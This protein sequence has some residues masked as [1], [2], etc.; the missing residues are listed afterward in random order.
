MEPF[1]SLKYKK[2]KA[3]MNRSLSSRQ[4]KMQGNKSVFNAIE[5]VGAVQGDAVKFDVIMD[6]FL[7]DVGSYDK[8]MLAAIL[9]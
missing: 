3:S 1:F 6:M 5:L 2:E 8:L 4:I 7:V 9:R